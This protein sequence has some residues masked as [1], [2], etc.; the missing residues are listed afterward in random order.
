[1][2]RLILLVF[3]FIV[4]STS[5]GYV[6]NLVSSTNLENNLILI[7]WYGPTNLI[8]GLYY[9]VYSSTNELTIQ[10]NRPV[11]LT[12]FQILGI[13]K[14]STNDSRYSIT[15]S[16]QPNKKYVIIPVLN[17]EYIYENIRANVIPQTQFPTNTNIIT[18]LYTNQ[19]QVNTNT[20]IVTN[21]VLTQTNLQ[22]N[23]SLAEISTNNTMEYKDKSL[24]LSKIIRE[25]FLKRDYR[26]S[27]EK[28][29]VI[30]EEVE[31]QEQRDLI[32]VYIARSYYALNKRKKA[33]YIL[34]RITSEEV[35]PLAEFWL[36][37]F[38]KYYR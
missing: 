20:N 26:A 5:F 10:N 19:L 14:Y 8:G 38:S 24:G 23:V 12:D 37:R 1:M 28:L 36:D 25:Y 11:N 13:L 3:L 33:I 29:R 31:T 6:Y 35:R 2:K 7:Q 18:N 15:D 17:G 30:R 27:L 34:L 21:T 22:T 9:N 32:D 4:A 16:L